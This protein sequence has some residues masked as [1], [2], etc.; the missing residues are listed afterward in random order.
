METDIIN[1]LKI[2]NERL[3][4]ENSYLTKQL[5]LLLRQGKGVQNDLA[6]VH[7]VTKHSPL[8]DKLSLYKSLFNGRSDMYAKHW[9]GK[10]GKSNYSPACSLQWHPQLCQLTKKIKCTDCKNRSFYPITD[11]VLADHLG[12]KHI[13]GLYPLQRDNTCSFLAVDFDKQNWQDDVLVLTKTCREIGIPYSI[14]RSRSG[15][16]AHV[17][18][19]FSK[20]V[21]A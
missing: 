19:F 17:W 15:N 12:G 1:N 10:N 14:E 7:L 9:I 3:R 20:N 4:N 13:V 11:Q 8:Q 6:D 5:A 2:E 21:P 18:F 16:G